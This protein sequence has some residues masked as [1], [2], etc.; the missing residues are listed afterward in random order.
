MNLFDPIAAAITGTI[1]AVPA[2]PGKFI[3]NL[4]RSPRLGGGPLLANGKVVGV[5]L[6]NRDSDQ[7]AI[8]IATLDDL[9][10]LLAEAG[11]PG[12]PTQAFD[13][14]SITMQLTA[15]KENR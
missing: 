4:S 3:V 6:A 13:A 10:K 5:Q 15:M 7:H 11:P 8:A 12:P 9:K 2:T 14:K 1:A